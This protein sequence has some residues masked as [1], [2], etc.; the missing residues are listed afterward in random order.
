MTVANQRPFYYVDRPDLMSLMPDKYLSIAIPVAVYWLCAIPFDI[1]DYFSP[2]S[3]EKYRI[4]DSAEVQSKNRVSKSRVIGTVLLQQVLQVV[5]A[6]WWLEDDSNSKLNH[7]Q[8]IQS[9]QAFLTQ[10]IL[11]LLGAENAHRFASTTGP[12]LASWLYWWGIPCLQ[13]VWAMFVMDTW[14]YAFHRLFHTIPFLYQHI[15]SWHHRL[16]VPFA[17]GALYNHP[18]EGLMLDIIGSLVALSLAGLTNRQ[19]ILLFGVATAKTIHDH[20]GWS[21]PFDPMQ[22]MFKNNADYHDIHHQLIGIKNNFSQPFFVHWDSL[23]G[24]E[25]TREELESRRQAN[26]AKAKR[27]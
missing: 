19:S 14:Q 24:T 21:L 27:N 10:G 4:H 11:R 13:F 6:L 1:L 8:T 17:Y 15:H 22:F 23:L 25:M 3:L 7:A 20:S 12:S 18:I 5:L 26:R 2:A 9:I 16:Y